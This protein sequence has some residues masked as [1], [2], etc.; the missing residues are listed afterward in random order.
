MQSPEAVASGLCA[1]R[2]RN[3]LLVHQIETIQYQG[4]QISNLSNIK[5]VEVHYLAP[6][7]YEVMHERLL[8]VA[9]GIDFRE[10]P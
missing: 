7:G 1:L 6:R 4:D 10:G 3:G 8:R 2:V 9:G 5:P